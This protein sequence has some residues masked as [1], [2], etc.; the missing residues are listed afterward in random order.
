MH[1]SFSSWWRIGKKFNKIWDKISNPLKKGFNSEPVYDNK[2]IKTN[3]KIYNNRINTNFH[4][5]KM[6]EE[7]EYYTC[8]SVILLDSLVKIDNDY[9]P[10]IF[11]E[12]CKYAVKKKKIMNTI[13]EEL[14]LDES[15][16]ESDN[17]KSNE[18]D[19]NEDCVL[20]AFLWI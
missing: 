6:P 19:E 14:N 13:N 9:Y 1:E 7:N 11:V 16:D 3:V 12:E 4:G 8:L 10:Q 18:S 20:N 5:N 2:Y 17:D 15:D